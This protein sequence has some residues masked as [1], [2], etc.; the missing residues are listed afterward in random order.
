M[1]VLHIKL[2]MSALILVVFLLL[3]VR[4]QVNSGKDE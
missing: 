4:N 1:A 3:F 2:K